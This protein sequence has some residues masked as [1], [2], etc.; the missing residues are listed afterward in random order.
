MRVFVDRSAS[1][2]RYS[3][4]RASQDPQLM[5]AHI[6]RAIEDSGSTTYFWNHFAALYE[7]LSETASFRALQ[8]R[9]LSYCTLPAGSRCL[10]LG[11]GTGAIARQLH[12]QGHQVVA[13]DASAPMIRKFQ[14]EVTE[15][16]NATMPPIE[17]RCATNF[18]VLRCLPDRSFDLI[19]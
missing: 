16:S 1:H 17:I 4:S 13:V 7:R 6:R 8:Q 15:A 19:T 9:F 12:A 3:K 18:E 5:R 2:A 10:D 11:C 14:R